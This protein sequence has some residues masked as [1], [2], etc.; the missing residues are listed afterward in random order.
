MERRCLQIAIALF[1]LVPLGAGLFGVVAGT[2]M[3]D[4]AHAVSADSHFRY[5]SGLLLGIGFAYLTTL[6]RIETRSD[7]F[8]MLTGIVFVGGLARLWSLLLDGAP[9]GP[10]LFGL[11]MELL[12]TPALCMWQRRVARHASTGSSAA[13]PSR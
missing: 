10:M 4:A 3:V 12:V 2:G 7:A 9:D 6:P 5:L 8:L 11:V 1:C 13:R